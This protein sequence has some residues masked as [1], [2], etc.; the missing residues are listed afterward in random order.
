MTSLTNTS[1]LIRKLA[2]PVVV[3][4][5]VSLLL[6]LIYFRFFTKDDTKTL[7][8]LSK[9][10]ITA[11]PTKTTSFSTNNLKV[12]KTPKKLDVFINN[13]DK[14]TENDNF[15]ILSQ[16]NLKNEPQPLKD[17]NRGE[18]KLFSADK[19]FLIIYESTFV[20]QAYVD[21]NLGANSF[22]LES[23]KQKSLDLF[24]DFGITNVSEPRTDYSRFKGEDVEKVLIP[25]EANFI[26]FHYNHLLNGFKVIS[27]AELLTSTYDSNGSIFKLELTRFQPGNTKGVYPLISI[28]KAIELLKENALLI[29]I[30]GT[31]EDLTL[32][33]T[34]AS[35][36]L[37]SAYLAYYFSY[38]DTDIQPVWVFEGLAKTVVGNVEVI[39]VT[40]AVD[41]RFFTQP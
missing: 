6:T 28:D 24:R 22:N 3:F 36:D 9:P 7:S 27:N 1:T 32:L 39:Y 40:P 11:L 10:Q 19:G 31:R 34:I 18:G 37:K 14:F 26:N 15:T 23:L 21:K 35:T 5:V 4:V 17:V 38:L 41:P 8:L 29:N 2:P 25:T 12:E 13:H 30:T 16:F 33:K 20:Y